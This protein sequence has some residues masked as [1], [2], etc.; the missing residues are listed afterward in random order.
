MTLRSEI[1]LR[2]TREKLREVE[3]LY[4]RAKARTDERSRRLGMLSLKKVINQLK[5]EIAIFEAHRAVKS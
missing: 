1:E 5:E 4:E 2:N 3:Q